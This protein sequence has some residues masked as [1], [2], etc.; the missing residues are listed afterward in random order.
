ITFL[1]LLFGCS[2]FLQKAVSC[3]KNKEKQVRTPRIREPN[4]LVVHL[5]NKHHSIIVFSFFKSLPSFVLGVAD[6][7]IVLHII[8]DGI[9]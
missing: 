6:S 4:V 9:G 3:M 5:S 2:H 8:V 7:F 1:G